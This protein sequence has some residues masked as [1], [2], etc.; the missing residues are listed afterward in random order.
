MLVVADS[1]AVLSTFG[2]ARASVLFG[3]R[4]SFWVV[5]P[6]FCLCMALPRTIVN[7]LYPLVLQAA[8]RSGNN[9]YVLQRISTCFIYLYL[10]S[11]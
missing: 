3:N 4:W 6:W 7:V 1:P 9:Y 11:M 2:M 8:P 10:W 5:V